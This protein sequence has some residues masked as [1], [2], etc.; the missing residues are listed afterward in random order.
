MTTKEWDRIAAAVRRRDWS[1]ALTLRQRC[2]LYDRIRAVL[3][4]SDDQ[5]A[6]ALQ[7]YSDDGV[8]QMVIERDTAYL[9][10]IEVGLRI[11]G[12]SR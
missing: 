10:G 12:G 2:D 11:A 9:I 3:P 7:T 6:K 8:L 1:R 5:A 4:P